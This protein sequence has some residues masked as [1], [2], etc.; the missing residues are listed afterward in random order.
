MTES[1]GAVAK[2]FGVTISQLRFYEKE[3]LLPPIKRDAAGRRQYQTCDLAL[4]Q[5]IVNLKRSNAS[6][7]E[8]AKFLDLY[9]AGAA[10]LGAR[11]HFFADQ[12]AKLDAQLAKLQTTKVYVQYKHW[13]YDQAQAVGGVAELTATQCELGDQFAAYL[14]LT[15]QSE[16]LAL[17]QQLLRRYPAGLCAVDL[18][19]VLVGETN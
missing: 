19:T 14:R 16:S 12:T 18:D 1:I 4:I 15:G 11:A 8:I 13:Y 5:Q 2:K 7:E 10:T 6:L 17:F 9:R 3:G